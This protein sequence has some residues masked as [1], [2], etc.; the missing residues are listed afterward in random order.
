[1]KTILGLC[2]LI[3]MLTAYGSGQYKNATHET[4]IILIAEKDSI[5]VYKAMNNANA[6]YF[7]NKGGVAVH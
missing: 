6:V 4:D 3:I 1:M 7:T 5:R 2:L